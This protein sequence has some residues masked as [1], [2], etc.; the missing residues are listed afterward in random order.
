MVNGPVPYNDFINAIKLSVKR[1]IDEKSKAVAFE[2]MVK[3]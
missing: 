2:E 1:R 3:A